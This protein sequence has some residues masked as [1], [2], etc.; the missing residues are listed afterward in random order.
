[1]KAFL[2]GVLLLICGATATA[3]QSVDQGPVE[4]R[5]FIFPFN[6]ICLSQKAGYQEVKWCAEV[7]GQ[8]SIK[9]AGQ[10]CESDAREVR[11]APA[12]AMREPPKHCEHEYKDKSKSKDTQTAS[13]RSSG[14]GND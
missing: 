7:I 11:A 6:V 1:M 10:Q 8:T 14:S 4:C 9:P 5:D 13:A 12:P 3:A 2:L